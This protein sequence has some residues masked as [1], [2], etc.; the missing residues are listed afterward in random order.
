[1]KKWAAIL[2][3][4]LIAFVEK[5]ETQSWIRIN[6]LG[7]TPTGVKVAVWCSKKQQAIDNWQLVE[8]EKNEVV[9]AGKAGKAF[10]PYG[11]FTQTYRLNFQRLNNR[12][13][14]IY[15]PAMLDHLNLKSVTMYIKELLIFVCVICGNNEVVSILF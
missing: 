13:D 8:I 2:F 7:Y 10:G 11:P 1:M 9:Y 12:E 6:Q 5:D 15:R 3:I 4:P 14:I